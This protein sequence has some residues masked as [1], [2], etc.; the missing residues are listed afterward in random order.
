MHSGQQNQKT[1]ANVAREKCE[2]TWQNASQ[3]RETI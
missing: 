1:V 2:E 3:N